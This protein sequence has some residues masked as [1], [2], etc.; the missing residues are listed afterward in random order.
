MK[1]TA[2]RFASIFIALMMALVLVGPAA[3]F[4]EGEDGQPGTAEIQKYTGGDHATGLE[5]AT[6]KEKAAFDKLAID[7]SRVLPNQTSIAAANTERKVESLPLLPASLAAP[8]SK[9]LLTK[10]DVNTYGATPGFDS[11]EELYGATYPS[12]TD[13]SAKTYFPPIGNQLDLNSCASFTTTYYLMTYQ[14]AKTRGWDAKNNS[15]LRFSPKFTYNLINGGENSNTSM[16]ANFL[17]LHY[18]GA[19]LNSQGFTYDGN[20][21][22]WPTKASQ[23]RE[24]MKYKTNLFSDGTSLKP[25]GLIK[26]LNTTDRNGKVTGIN[27]LKQKLANG[28]IVVMGTPYFNDWKYTTVS[29][30]GGTL[31]DPYVG[32]RAVPY[33]KDSG[34]YYGHA[35]TIVGYNENLW[36]DCNGNG[37]VDTNE[38]GAFKVVNSWGTAANGWPYFSG[39]AKRTPGTV[40]VSYNA[41]RDISSYKVKDQGSYT[42]I[43]TTDIAANDQCYFLMVPSKDYVPALTADVTVTTSDRYDLSAYFGINYAE[44]TE[45]MQ[46]HSYT[47]GEYNDFNYLHYINDG[48]LW[49]HHWSDDIGTTKDLPFQGGI[50]VDLTPYLYEYYAFQNAGGPLDINLGILDTS[51]TGSQEVNAVKFKNEKTGQTFNALEFT[52][53]ATVNDTMRWFYGRNVLNPSATRPADANLTALADMPTGSAQHVTSTGP[54]S[55]WERKFRPATTAVYRLSYANGT[56]YTNIE[57]L[58]SARQRLYWGMNDSGKKIEQ[59]LYAGKTY[60][61][62]A[63]SSSATSTFDLTLA[64]V[65]ADL[66]LD[67]SNCYLSGITP[68][69]GSLKEVF[70]KGTLAYTMDLAEA[71]ASVTLSAA[72]EM[73]GA[74]VTVDGTANAKTVT[75]DTGETKKVNIVVT[76]QD[77]LYTR[78]YTVAVTRAKSSVATLSGITTSV[79]GLNP[80]FAS[81]TTEYSL[82]M[83]E[84]TGSVTFTPVKSNAHADMKIDNVPAAS[85]T[86]SLANGGSVDVK[87][88]LVSQNGVNTADY[89]IHLTRAKSN[90]SKLSGITLSTGKLSPTFNAAT[91]AY[92]ISLPENTASV[93]VTPAKALGVSAMSINGNPAAANVTLAPDNGK[94]ATATIKVTSQS[95]TSSTTYTVSATRAPSTNYYLSRVNATNGKWNKSFSHKSTSYTLSLPEVTGNGVTTLTPI[96]ENHN[97]TVQYIRGGSTVTLQNGQSTTVKLKVTAQSGARRYKYYTITIS[98]PKSSNNR[99]AALTDNLG[100]LSPAFNP[101]DTARTYYT[102]ALGEFDTGVTIRASKQESHATLRIDGRI[103][104]S[105]TVSVNPGKSTDVKISVRSQSGKTKTYTVHITRAPSTNTN[106]A[107]IRTNSSSFPVDPAFNKS[108]LEYTVKLPAGISSVTVYAK[109]EN[110][111]ATVTINKKKA[112]SQRISV[113]LNGEQTVY[114]VVTAQNKSIPPKQYKV[115]IVRGASV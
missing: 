93:L 109:A 63:Y 86:V 75:V 49:N 115:R 79:P 105:K 66:D 92:T 22:D 39:D 99:L 46:D 8:D 40:W 50:T 97:A 70:D 37:A 68:S 81:G 91:Q 57:I 32:Q 11:N 19:M 25:F 103:A 20:E 74:T 12:A 21:K 111:Y 10:D 35:L 77:M 48:I 13:L 95:G 26:G 34:K 56:A 36:I 51:N 43:R 16:E 101:A 94:T 55:V 62:R 6:E 61:I 47:S 5:E 38:K 78:T 76:S 73:A 7:V 114:I 45:P 67:V 44:A 80:S 107:Y 104:T 85:K 1:K 17:T 64:K 53:P 110:G 42:Y 65:G 89:V 14:T 24:A 30:M 87:I 54:A 82:S 15:N 4:A 72:K 28:D 106:L 58:N 113:P 102:L 18:N 41:F 69:I 29:N 112:T 3:V 83:P 60:V 98:R 9:T 88:H 108:T 2:F 100:K 84:L 33:M 52:D 90:N 27:N 59:R 71:Q 23:W 96:P 31:D